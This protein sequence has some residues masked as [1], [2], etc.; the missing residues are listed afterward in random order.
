MNANTLFPATNSR[1]SMSPSIESPQI[2]QL[3]LNAEGGFRFRVRLPLGVPYEIQASA[4]IQTWLAVASGIGAGEPIE[5]AD[6]SGADFSTRFYRVIAA[7]LPLPKRVGYAVI[8]ISPGISMISN[9]FHAADNNIGSL[10]CGMP[11][12][13]AV[14]K[15]DT[16]SFR[17]TNNF[18]KNGQWSRPHDTLLPGEGAIICNPA[19]ETKTITF[20]GEV[21]QGAS[22]NRIT[23]GFSIRS[24]VLPKAGRLDLDLNFPL[25]DGDVVHLFDRQQQRYLVYPYPSA[26][27]ETNPP[28]VS[29]GES[30]WIGKKSAGDWSQG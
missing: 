14:C 18:L 28:R 8:Q 12:G 25:T 21:S 22:L 27:W 15:F 10:F 16:G 17:L 7:G 26:L 4:D 30:F 23:S 1:H 20:F 13:T 6:P 9:P 2:D 24:S 5:F 29:V 11:D 19:R 3:G